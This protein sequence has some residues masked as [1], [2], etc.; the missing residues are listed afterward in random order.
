MQGQG[1]I[2]SHPSTIALD[3][4]EIRQVVQKEVDIIRNSRHNHELVDHRLA[5]REIKD[6]DNEF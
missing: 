5:L 1:L 6:I 2:P 3:R 4:L